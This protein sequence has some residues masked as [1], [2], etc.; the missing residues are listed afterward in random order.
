MSIKKKKVLFICIHNSAR[1]QMAETFLND[2]GGEW[3]QAESAG[4][5][6][7]TLN[8]LVVQVMAEEGYDISGNSTNSVFDFYQQQRSYDFVVAVCSKEAEERCPIFPGARRRLHWP[9]DDPSSMGG[10]EQE[11][12]EA[13]RR[14]RDQIKAKIGEFIAEEKSS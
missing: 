8:P 9:F 13:T 6:P 10:S 2:L 11:R 1:S 4:L 14:I 3:F 12:L 5:E 7:G